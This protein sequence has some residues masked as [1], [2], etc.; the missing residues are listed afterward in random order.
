ML[1]NDRRSIFVDF[2]FA[3]LP[4]FDIEVFGRL[5]SEHEATLQRKLSELQRDLERRLIDVKAEH[6]NAIRLMTLQHRET[7][8]RIET[9][10]IFYGRFCHFPRVPRKS[11][12]THQGTHKLCTNNRFQLWSY[13]LN[14]FGT[15]MSWTTTKTSCI[16]SEIRLGPLGS[17]TLKPNHVIFEFIGLVNN[18][19]VTQLGGAV[20][21]I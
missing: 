11:A 21:E 5:W 8:T 19:T 3:L 2:I 20:Q 18:T 12:P 17:R 6:E 1:L 16:K 4:P 9:G 10:Q 15:G 14:V 13:W 7:I